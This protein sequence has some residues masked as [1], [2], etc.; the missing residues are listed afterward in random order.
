M[1]V[2]KWIVG[3]FLV[4]MIAGALFSAQL[5]QRFKTPIVNLPVGEIAY[6]YIPTGANF[7][8][9]CDSL[10]QHNLVLD[11]GFFELLAERKNYPSKVKPGR[12]K[13]RSELTAN[14]LVNMLR[15]GAQEP[16][17]ITFN[18]L[19]FADEIVTKVHAKLEF[20][21]VS[22]MTLMHDVD[23]MEDYGFDEKNFVG[24]FLP[25]TYEFYWN[26][27]AEQFIEKMNQEYHKF[28]TEERKAEAKALDMTQQEISVLA[29]VVQSETLKR[30]EMA[31]VAGLYINRIQKGI[32]LQADPTV[33]FAVGDF[34][35]TRILYSHLEYDSPYNTYMYAG[36][37][38]GP[39]C[40]PDKQTLDYTLKYER[41]GFIYMCAKSDGSRYHVFAKTL[42]QH[43]RN[44]AA[45]HRY[46]REWRRKNRN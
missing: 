25:D 18:N 12:Y 3:I 1:K 4:L 2:W 38:P 8:T 9:V 28:W 45:Y 13:L 35:L 29:S 34:T 17:R 42:G 15:S 10:Y 43:N 30:D 31:R 21:S 7:Q 39:I 40:M 37:P 41:H 16:V 46:Y 22:L 26:T 23:L 19:R 14:A 32:L 6:L 36:L 24:M 33:K 5:Y 11:T 44:A 20:D 27:S